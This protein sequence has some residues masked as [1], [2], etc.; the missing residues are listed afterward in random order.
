MNFREWYE[1]NQNSAAPVGPHMHRGD[2][3]QAA[4]DACKTEVLT[5]IDSTPLGYRTEGEHEKLEKF[6]N[7]IFRKIQAL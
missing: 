3:C 1:H 7:T 2:I 5:I 4:W 6:T